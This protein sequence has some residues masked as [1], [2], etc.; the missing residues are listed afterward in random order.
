MSRVTGEVLGSLASGLTT[1]LGITGPPTPNTH[2]ALFLPE[3]LPSDLTIGR[4]LTSGPHIPQPIPHHTSDLTKVTSFFLGLEAMALVRLVALLALL[5]A[6]VSA[7]L[8]CFMTV[9]ERR[10]VCQGFVGMQG[11]S[12]RKCEDAFK[13]AF[14]GLEDVEISYKD[15]GHLHDVFTEMTH[16]LQETALT[17]KPYEEAFREAAASVEENIAQLKEAPDC[18]PPCGIQEVSRRF[19]CR[20][21]YSEVCDL[22]LDC[23]V[24]DMKVIRG[25]QAMFSCDVNFELPEP[26]TY[27]WKFVGGGFRTQDQTYFRELPGARGNVARIRP[28]QPKHRGTFSCEIAHEQRP[29]ARLYFFLNVTGP[30]PRG[31]SELQV[32][33]REVVRWAP[34]EAELLEP[35]RPSLVELLASPG[36]LTPSNWGLLAANAAVLAAGVT[37]LAW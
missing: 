21:C 19:L 15:R 3:S 4:S 18:I 36:A 7:C 34:R 26:V 35:W 27:T 9:F 30:P 33:F 5:A 17:Q 24:Q 14:G 29:L 11:A 13:A 28:V 20:W 10:R 16:S 12:L 1:S 22:P 23:P 32:S 6:P 8:L 2:I 31:E 37:L 25:E